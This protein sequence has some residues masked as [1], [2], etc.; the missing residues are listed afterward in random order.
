MTTFRFS[1]FAAA[2][3][4][5]LTVAAGGTSDGATVP[6]WGVPTNGGG[7]EWN[8]PLNS[9]TLTVSV[10]EI[11]P[12]GD[13]SAPL[14]V[15]WEI[16][17]SGS[18]VGE[19]TA[20]FTAF[21]P[22]FTRITYVVHTGD[23]GLYRNERVAHAA[24][25]S[26]AFEYG[27]NP[28]HVYSNPGTYT[29]RSIYVYD[30]LGAWGV[31]ALPDLVV[32]AP[33]VVYPPSRTIVIS[34][35]PGET[36]A[37]APPHDAA[38]RCTTIA[39]AFARF[40][41]VSGVGLGV[42]FCLKAGTT[43]PEAFLIAPTRFRNHAL[44]DTWGGSAKPLITQIGATGGAQGGFFSSS[45]DGTYGFSVKNWSFNF[46][47]DVFE[48][49]PVNGYG[50]T[51]AQSNIRSLFQG[52]DA[53]EP[54]GVV[55]YRACFDNLDV[56]GCGEA[57]LNVLDS[58]RR[59]AFFLNDCKLQRNMDY[60]AFQGSNHFMLGTEV[61]EEYGVG[62]GL[63][64]RYRL[65]G[66]QRGGRGHRSFRE[67]VTWV[68]YIRASFIEGR[69]GWSGQEVDKGRTWYAP[70]GIFRLENGG[71]GQPGKRLYICDSVLMNRFNI[72]NGNG[73]THAVIEN[74]LIVYDP[75]AWI[76]T[77]GDRGIVQAVFGGMAIRNNEVL[78][79]N[80]PVL[81]EAGLAATRNMSKFDTVSPVTI[82]Q[83]P[84]RM[85][86][87]ADRSTSHGRPL[88]LLHNTTVQLRPLSRI[89]NGTYEFRNTDF[90][91]LYPLAIGHNV[92][93]A[94][95][96][97]IGP[98]MSLLDMPAG[99]RVLDVWMKM[100]W[101]RQEY[102]LPTTIGPG[103][104][105]AVIPYPN[106]WYNNPT[107]QASYAGTNGNHGVLLVGPPATTFAALP[108]AINNGVPDYRG[109]ITVNF[110]AGGFT[111]TNTSSVSWPSGRTIWILLDRGSTGMEPDLL[112]DVDQAPLK[113]YRPTT[114]QPMTPNVRSTLFD[115][116]RS[117]RPGTTFAISPPG[118]NAAGMLL[119]AA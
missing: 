46:G 101:E 54:A 91:S 24:H 51:S 40:N 58:Y 96:M 98:A 32:L 99:V 70:Q 92:E 103:Q 4:V 75:A 67:N 37:G 118:Q 21:D 35:A 53:H 14:A 56:E 38:N 102:V 64:G 8:G 62:L 2:S 77:N 73:G 36:W 55:G 80:T 45:N 30:D 94:P 72:A 95:E 13:V 108:Y 90:D 79:L 11:I 27:Q 50:T 16:T 22:T 66:Y 111:I 110:Q 41:A 33:E 61:V 74:N 87:I 107:T 100:F 15:E 117:I 52:S 65:G 9:E 5:A 69:G 47:S 60:I 3:T 88:D 20:D 34:N 93:Y 48:E 89:A 57:V 43:Y 106:D 44:F 84:R 6:A 17:V 68:M 23:T 85:F 26:K 78:V 109:A 115:F 39:Q 19:R 31:L 29:G 10:Q 12:P 63:M 114:P 42:R 104:T 76:D 82:G 119:P 97:G 7:T 83:C 1:G 116:G 28:G 112:I 113:L 105:T 86:D 71:V 25:R 18:A 59:G 49:A 81:Q